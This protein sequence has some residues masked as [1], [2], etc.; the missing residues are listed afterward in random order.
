MTECFCTFSAAPVIEYDSSL[1]D[2]MSLKAGTS[3]II[4][5]EVK[6]APTPDVKWLL[7]D[8]EVTQTPNVTIEGDGTFSRWDS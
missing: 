1:K 7:G 5:V 4:S 6:G 2:R 3:L 8:Q